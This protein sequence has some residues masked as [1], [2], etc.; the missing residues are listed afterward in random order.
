[1]S[2]QL[3]E[4]LS[5]LEAEAHPDQREALRLS[6]GELNRREGIGHAVAAIREVID[7]TPKPDLQGLLAEAR[8]IDRALQQAIAGLR[9]VT[10]AQYRQAARIC[11]T[12]LGDEGQ[13]Q[14]YE[15]AAA[16]AE[17]QEVP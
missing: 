16:A 1:M 5:W 10:I 17:H 7:A 6:H 12:S 4:V 11:R 9:A 15:A 3:D 14:R 13:A 2:P 8:Q